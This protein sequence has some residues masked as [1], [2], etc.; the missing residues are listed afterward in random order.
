[1]PPFWIELGFGGEMK[2]CEF[3]LNGLTLESGHEGRLKFKVNAL[4]LRN[5][6][7]N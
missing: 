6:V 2:C 1:M 4:K 3:H 5:F 7:E